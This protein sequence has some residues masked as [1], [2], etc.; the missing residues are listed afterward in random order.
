ME[1]DNFDKQTRDYSA[2]DCLPI[3]SAVYRLGSDI[4]P[5]SYMKFDCPR[6]TFHEGYY[7]IE[8]FLIKQ[9]EDRV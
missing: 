9:T 1:S 8:S 4:I 7:R 3:L 2:S 5:D 6:K